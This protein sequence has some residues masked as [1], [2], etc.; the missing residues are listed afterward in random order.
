MWLLDKAL[1]SF[2]G[3][4]K[5]PGALIVHG[6]P[7]VTVIVYAAST[8]GACTTGV[9]LSRPAASSAHGLYLVPL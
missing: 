9:L 7:S 5:S 2:R 3:H 8:C 1:V 4:I 6:M